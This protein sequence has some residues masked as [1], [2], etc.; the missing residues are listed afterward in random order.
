M[1]LLHGLL[2][3]GAFSTLFEVRSV[4]DI[5]GVWYGEVYAIGDVDYETA[6]RFSFTVMVCTV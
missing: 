1:L 3:T 5:T 6:T 4:E 2:C